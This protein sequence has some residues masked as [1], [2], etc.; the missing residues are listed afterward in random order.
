ML[1]FLKNKFYFNC[2]CFGLCISLIFLIFFFIFRYN[3]LCADDL[4]YNF[5]VHSPT[6]HSDFFYGSWV[7][8]LQ[9]I[10]MYVIPYK[11]GIHFQT[12]A[13][14]MGSVLKAISLTAIFIILYKTLDVFNLKLRY[15]A[16]FSAIFLLFLFYSKN[17]YIDFL[18]NSGFFRFV[19]PSSLM[20][21]LFYLFYK[22]F[23]DLKINLIF[24]SLLSFITAYS[25]EIA[26]VILILFSSFIILYKFYLKHSFKSCIPFFIGFVSLFIGF[27]ILISSHGF[28]MHLKTKLDI[29]SPLSS[30]FFYLPEYIPVFFKAI[31]IDY[32]IFW[33]IVIFLLIINVKLNA[34][35][36]IVFSSMIFLSILILSFS[37]ILL[38]KTHYSQGF[39]INHADLYTVF[40]SLAFYAGF[41]LFIPILNFFDKNYF[42]HVLFSVFFIIISILFYNTSLSLHERIRTLEDYAY[43][44]DKMILFYAYRNETPIVSI[45]THL[46]NVYFYLTPVSDLNPDSYLKELGVYPDD[47][48]VGYLAMFGHYYPI[49]YDQHISD[50]IVLPHYKA[51]EEF[52]LRGGTYDEI[53]SRKYSFENL[54][55]KNFVLNIK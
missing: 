50:V 29:L 13:L 28:L 53:I 14:T 49:C 33:I 7:M 39:W 16:S 20:L 51:M 44:R 38:G 32:Y 35:I 21:I 52:V 40:F 15:L 9:N 47:R 22:T 30:I 34:H 18:I 27:F 17:I 48:K 11:L 19:I 6:I 45:F 42:F 31:F 26:A 36:N 37:L 23:S 4:Q 54:K 24:L 1:T 2:V 46:V 10:S 43:L 25:S 41:I 12:W 5:L 8:Q 55:D 3:V